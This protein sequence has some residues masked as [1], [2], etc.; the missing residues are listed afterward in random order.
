MKTGSE[1][2]LD[3]STL[4]GIIQISRKAMM[5]TSRRGDA[6]QASPGSVRAGRGDHIENPSGAAD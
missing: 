1:P 3:I 5:E 2:R 6:A 4:C